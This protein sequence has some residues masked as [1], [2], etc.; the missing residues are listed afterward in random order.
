MA[1]HR[2]ASCSGVF[3][4]CEYKSF[5]CL[6]M[7]RCKA[8]RSSRYTQPALPPPGSSIRT[9]L[10][11]PSIFSCKIIA[12]ISLAL[13]SRH[14]R[15]YITD[16]HINTGASQHIQANSN[17]TFTI[18]IDQFANKTRQRTF[19]H[20]NLFATSQRRT[21][22]AYRF[23]RIIKHETET[24]HLLVR[25]YSRTTLAAHH[26]VTADSRKTQDFHAFL[27]AMDSKIGLRV[28]QDSSEPPGIMDGPSRA[29]SSPPDTP[30]PTKCRPRALISFSRR[31]VS[32]K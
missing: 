32:G 10:N 16:R 31:M 1:K 11:K 28:F 20:A 18:H 27:T 2:V 17:L 7:D 23:F 21:V 4:R 3:P 19:D 30:Q 29:P 24:S 15:L 5:I 13:N 8:E 12:Y 9:K 25:N 14:N 6:W 26:H 22:H